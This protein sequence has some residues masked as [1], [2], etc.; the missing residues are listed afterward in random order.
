MGMKQ[1]LTIGTYNIPFIDFTRNNEDNN[2]NV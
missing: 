1:R 2:H